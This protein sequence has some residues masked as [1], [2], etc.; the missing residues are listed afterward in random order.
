MPAAAT[1]AAA[2]L[3][4]V[5]SSQYRNPASLPDGGVLVVGASASGVQIA[6]ELARAGR[7]V[8]LA[9]GRHTRMP[10]QYRG[11]D[12]MWW[13]DRAGVLDDRAGDIPAAA[14][15]QPSL[16]IVGGSRDLD[17]GTLASAGVRIAGR[18]LDVDGTSARFAD[19]LATTAADADRRLHRLLDRIDACAGRIEGA[20][21]PVPIR[22]PSSPTSADL[23]AEGITTIVWATG[24]RPSFP[25]LHVPVLDT[26]GYVEHRGGVAAAP[27]LYVVGMRWQTRRSSTFIDGVRHDARA[28][29]DHLVTQ[30]R[31]IAA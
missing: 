19:D 3:H 24:H 30:R 1:N 4:Q 22:L 14:Q 21:R 28:V 5:H 17:L 29:V 9:V 26:A 15:Q 18:V 2:S 25:W 16:Q 10:R 6:D 8:T 12:T 7:A 23:R 20:D 27:G 13:F 11:R 31:A